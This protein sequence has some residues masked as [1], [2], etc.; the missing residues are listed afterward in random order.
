M[1]QKK[2]IRKRKHTAPTKVRSKY[3]LGGEQCARGTK[4][5]VQG[6]RPWLGAGTELLL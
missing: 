2:K 4:K 1:K 6:N 5:L 3:W